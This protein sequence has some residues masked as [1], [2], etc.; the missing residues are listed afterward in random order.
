MKIKIARITKGL[1]QEELAEKIN[2]TRPLVSHVEQ[3]GKVNEH[4]LKKICQVLD[5]DRAALESEVYEPAGQYQKGNA[6]KQEIE[7]LKEEIAMLKELINMQKEVI[8]ELRK[9]TEKK[10]GK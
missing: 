3:T 10:A 5:I 7:R 4:T 6:Q 1:T 9:K 2:K 8:T